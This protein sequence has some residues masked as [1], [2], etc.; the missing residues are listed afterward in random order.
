VKLSTLASRSLL[1]VL[2]IV[3]LFPAGAFAGERFITRWELTE[4]QLNID[5]GGRVNSIAVHPD[6]RNEMFVASETGGL[7][8]SLDGGHQ[9]THVDT[10][11]V[12]FT[13]SVVYL[14]SNPNT[15]FVSAKADFKTKN[16]GGLWE[17]LNNG[18]TWHPVVL[19]IPNFTGRLSA[20]EISTVIGSEKLVVGTSEGIFVSVD[21]GGFWKYSDVFGRGNKAVYSVLVENGV[22]P[23]IHAGGPSG[24]RFATTPFTSWQTPSIPPG[25]AVVQDIHAFGRS[26]LSAMQGFVVVNGGSDLYRTANGGASWIRIPSAPAGGPGCGGSAFIRVANKSINASK[27]LEL[28]FGN[29]CG[30][31]RLRAPYDPIAVE[32]DANYGGQWFAAQLDRGDT[33]DLGLFRDTPVLLGTNGGLHETV[34]NIHE[35]MIWTFVGGGRLGGYNALQVTEVEGQIVGDLFNPVTALYVATQDNG[36]HA[37]SPLGNVFPISRSGSAFFIELER[38]IEVGK[39]SELTFAPGNYAPLFARE[40]LTGLTPWNNPPG[41]AGK[42]AFVRRGQ[43]VQQVR[44]PGNTFAGLATTENSGLSWRRFAAYP[45]E[46]RDIPRLGRPGDPEGHSAAERMSILYQPYRSNAPGQPIKLMRIERSLDSAE[47]TAVYPDMIGFEGLGVNPTMFAWYQVFGVDPGNADHIIAPDVVGQEVR[48]S[49]NGGRTWTLVQDLKALVMAGGAGGPLLFRTD[50]TGG[51]AGEVFPLITAVS[52]CPADPQLVV[53]GTSEGGI[54]F[55]SNNGANW[56]PIAGS[57]R[58]TYITSFFWQSANTVFV[59]TYGRGLWKLNNRRIAVAP[60]FDETCAGCDVIAVDSGPGRPSFDG[61]VLAFEGRMLGVR[62][63]KGQVREVFVSPGSSVLFTGDPD[64]PQDD[65]AVTESDGRDTSQFEPLP[66]GPDGWILTGIVFSKDDTLLGAAFAKSPISLVPPVSDQTVKGSTL[67]PNAGRPYIR[68]SSANFNG[69]ATVAP[70]ETFDLTATDF[71]AGVRY[72]VLVDGEALK[73]DVTADGSGS[74]QSRISAPADP[75]YHSV[76]VRLPGD[77]AVID[78]STFLV[79]NGN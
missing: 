71:V 5:E 36:M 62:T 59:S 3:F 10:L 31:H 60:V 15:L 39:D 49:K 51:R 79:S 63:E 74:F 26:P 43:W 7:F 28:Y 76:A 41:E 61:G 73:G 55:S 68:L 44:P 72:E 14:P 18:Q 45:D 35:G 13:Q 75:G 24:V 20:Y 54:F 11:P 19:T 66:K 23:R 58:A 65:I 34:T 2:C 21:G 6:K 33:R 52:F 27:F 47:A 12:I 29:R 48:E 50:L 67:S 16:G 22:T 53:A 30:L 1:I 38:R 46:P 57:D 9:W 32:P 42:P 4:N 37:A 56:K 40:H 69:V 17:S 78:G 8:K 64:D 77:E 70:Q 25:N